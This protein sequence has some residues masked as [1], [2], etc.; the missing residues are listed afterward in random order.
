MKPIAAPHIGRWVGYNAGMVGSAAQNDAGDELT[1][2]AAAV[3]PRGHRLRGAASLPIDQFVLSAIG[4]RSTGIILVTAPAGGGKTT[5]LRHLLATLPDDVRVRVF[6]SDRAERA[7]DACVTGPVILA[8]AEPQALGD[9]LVEVLELNAWTLDDCLEYLANRHRDQCASVL[10][11]LSSDTIDFLEGSP[12]LLSIVMDAMAADPSAADPREVLRQHVEKIFP[13]GDFLDRLILEGPAHARPSAEQSRLWRHMP[14]QRVCLGNWITGRLCDGIVPLQLHKMQEAA[15]LVEAIAIA[16]RRRPAAADRLKKL[17]REAGFSSAAAMAASILL[18]IDPN[19][20]PAT[21]RRLNLRGARL[22]NARWAGLDLSEARLSDAQMSGADLSGADLGKIQADGIDLG[23]ANLRQVL[24]DK[25][26]L[27]RANLESADLSG[28]VGS[29]VDLSQATLRS[30]VLQGASLNHARLFNTDLSDAHCESANFAHAQFHMVN[31]EDASFAGA[32]LANAT[33]ER[34]HLTQAKWDGACFVGVTMRTCNL[35][36]LELTAPDFSN[37]SLAG[38]LLTSSR[39]PGACFRGANL[40][41]C[42][43][44][45]IEW[46]NADLRMA[47]L[48]YASFHLGSTRS[49]LVGSTI[50]CEGSR[51]GFYTDE[52]NEQL[53]K[54]PEE[55]RKASLCG[56]N[57]TSAKIDG[58]D[59]YLVDLRRARYSPDQARHFARTGAILRS[60]EA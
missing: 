4:K 31:V 46:E 49:G 25:A 44:A 58:T 8:A 17:L 52:Y 28:A 34:V 37:A 30:A 59:F 57:L 11:R 12:Q 10:K 18:A 19:W 6:D 55:I 26:N 2:R 32:K 47:D 23:G 14:V 16:V 41:G 42:G 1:P 36:G 13:L 7:R 51:T 35:E 60:V 5:A 40:G 21:G 54:S 45:E 53:Y 33:L 56:A 43:L 27:C 29:E 38:C 22:N 50:P 3:R 15:H 9:D 24:L 39:M 20:R 48:R